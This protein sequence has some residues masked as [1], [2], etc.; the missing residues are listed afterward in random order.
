VSAPPR[1]RELG[2]ATVGAVGIAVAAWCP[3]FRLTRGGA[4]ESL[5]W[6]WD[7]GV[8]WT[9]LCA[10]V[11]LVG[12]ALMWRGLAVRPAKR[13]P[14]FGLRP[15][16]VATAGAVL[17]LAASVAIMVR[18]FVGD[19]VVFGRWAVLPSAPGLTVERGWGLF[20]GS[21]TGLASG[22]AALQV[23]LRHRRLPNHVGRAEGRR[24][25]AVPEGS[26]G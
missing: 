17:V 8:A 22:I 23:L 11:P 14:G 21:Q 16:A 13:W 6:S 9:V 4:T 18:T 12:L 24:T 26:L 19:G 15:S 25:G 2:P 7:V 1:D 20:I 5:V 10:V 3:W